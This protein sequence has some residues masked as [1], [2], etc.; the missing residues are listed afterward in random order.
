MEAAGVATVVARV[1]VA[2]RVDL[3]AERVAAAF[4]KALKLVCDRVVSPDVLAFSSDGRA[5]VF[6]ERR[7]DGHRRRAAVA[8]VEPAVGSPGETVGNRMR[9]LNAEALQ[10]DNRVGI[11]NVVL[12]GVGI[13]HQIRRRHNPHAVAI[14]CD[15]SR[16]IQTF[17]ED[18]MLV[19]MAVVVGIGVNADAVLA[20][21]RRTFGMRRRRSHAVVLHTPVL[22]AIDLMNAGRAGVLTI[23]NDPQP[24]VLVELHLH[25]LGNQRIT[26]HLFD[27]KVIITLHVMLRKRLVGRDRDGRQKGGCEEDQA[28]EGREGDSHLLT[29]ADADSGGKGWGSGELRGSSGEQAE[30]GA[31]P[32]YK[33][34]ILSKLGPMKSVSTLLIMCFAAS[35]GCSSEP[36]RKARPMT[37]Q[38]LCEK[39]S[40]EGYD[41][42]TE[43]EQLWLNVHT[44]IDATENGDLISY[45]YNSGADTFD[46]T[47]D[48]LDELEA[49]EVAEIVEAFGNFFGDEV[50]DDTQER[51]RVINSWPDGGQESEAC[52]AVDEILMPLFEEL[53]T[54]LKAYLLANGYDPG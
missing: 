41:E 51:N 1:N 37:W 11:G 39:W 31:C 22:I 14:E 28:G 49:N 24:I 27:D 45:F 12:I 50:P 46:D 36:I 25:R 16:N 21:E 33:S 13:E 40:R 53:E 4:G 52:E 48:A 7:G 19:V 5:I 30:F 42:L 2:G 23:L 38:E 35:F 18:L 10:V 6:P 9:V 47:V 34:K 3:Q 44:L 26:Q 32:L 20:T 43:Q 17:D 29:M 8:A 54:K 15:R